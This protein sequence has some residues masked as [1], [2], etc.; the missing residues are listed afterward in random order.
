MTIQGIKPEL[1][2]SL[3]DRAALESVSVDDLLTRYLDGVPTP[4]APSEI[5]YKL[6][7]EHTSDTISLFDLDLRYLYANPVITSLTGLNLADMIGKTDQELGMPDKNVRF[8][9]VNWQRVIETKQEQIISF[10]FL[11]VQGL[12]FYESRLTPIFDDAGMILWLLAIT[13]DV[14]RRQQT[15]DMLRDITNRLPCMILIY[16]LKPEGDV[17]ALFVS[18][19]SATIYEVSAEEAV[20][21]VRKLWAKIPP[22]DVAKMNVSITAS[23]QNLTMWE[24]EWRIRQNDGSIKWVS[25]QG[26]PYR[27]EDGTILWNTIVLDITDRKTLIQQQREIIEQLELTI[28][29]AQLGIWRLDTTTGTLEWND[30]MYDIYGIS[31]AAFTNDVASWQALLHPDDR[32]YVDERFNAIATKGLVVDVNFRI[33]RPDGELRYISASGNAL[34]DQNKLSL[35][36]FGVNIDVTERKRAEQIALERERLL[37]SLKMEKEHAAMIQGVAAKLGHDLRNSLAI[38]AMARDILSR[39]FEQ[40]DVNQRRERLETIANQL[41]HITELLN[42]LNLIKNS[43][44]MPHTVQ[45]KPT[46]MALMCQ[47]VLQD[48]Q[49]SIGVGHYLTFINDQGLN[50]AL[51]DNI[52]VNRILLNLLSNAVKYSP[53]GSEITLRLSS[54]ADKMILQVSDQGMGIAASDLNRIFEPY[55]RVDTV[56]TIEGTG[57]GLSIV[58]DCVERHHGRLSVVS[59]VGQGTT[60]EIELPLIAIPVPASS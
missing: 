56:K 4:A 29:T 34:P 21:D 49:D 33:V 14:T 19:G 18:T 11:T 48:I 7:L 2:Q 25:G 39:Y 22:D 58:K 42:D 47:I 35:V 38:I 6:L 27:L 51:V 52:L 17:Q 43:D 54:D 31:R 10:E 16:L 8:W 55:Y 9:K 3:Q 59:V 53:T 12:R 15:E 5:P 24:D 1:L 41:N 46:N 36:L 45:F 40:I 32:S 20:A 57:L 50:V 60:F 13:R 37:A 30:H 44:L 26:T 28:A 23:A